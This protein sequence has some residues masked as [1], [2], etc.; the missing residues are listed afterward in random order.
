LERK[1]GHQKQHISTV[2]LD[3]IWTM[4]NAAFYTRHTRILTDS[5]VPRT[6]S[7]FSGIPGVEEKLD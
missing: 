3:G 2:Q 1:R 6:R 5:I 4:D 7:V